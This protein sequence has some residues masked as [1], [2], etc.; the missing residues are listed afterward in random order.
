M[1]MSE[2]ELWRM[3]PRSFYN[4]LEGWSED[5]IEMMDLERD[6]FAFFTRL[7]NFYQVAPL[8]KSIHRPEDLYRIPS[9]ADVVAQKKD[10]LSKEQ[11]EQLVKRLE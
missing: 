11:F 4:K 7:I 1:G 5:R 3:T 2:A 6:R 8:S 9:D 10:P